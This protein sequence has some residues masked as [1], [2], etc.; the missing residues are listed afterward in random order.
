MMPQFI[1]LKGVSFNNAELP[2]LN[3]LSEKIQLLLSLTSWVNAGEDNYFT[4]EN[5]NLVLIDKSMERV[6]FIKAHSRTFGPTIQKN[7]LNGH[8]T[9]KVNGNGG[10]TGGM[11]REVHDMPVNTGSFTYAA[12]IKVTENSGANN[13]LVA[14]GSS[15]TGVPLWTNADITRFNISGSNGGV[16]YSVTDGLNKWL[17]LIG[18]FDNDTMTAKMLN[19][20]NLT[21][22]GYREVTSANTRETLYLGQNDSNSSLSKCEIAELI[23]MHDDIFKVGYEEHLSNVLDYF[24]SK[25]D[26]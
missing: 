1:K 19:P 3:D 7:S 23:V 22:V 20:T 14:T 5:G 4:D 17:I 16:E 10:D 11:I 21:A 6:N 12:V 2:V 25:F 8:N 24:K 26:L 13:N 15:T 18:S 9:I